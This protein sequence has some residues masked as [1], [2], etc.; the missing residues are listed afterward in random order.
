MEAESRKALWGE[1]LA[2]WIVTLLLIRLVVDAQR[3][4]GLHEVALVLVP[5]LFLY[6]PVLVCHWRKVDSWSYPLAIPRFRDKESWARIAKLNLWTIGVIVV[7][8]VVGYHLW[9]TQ[10]FPHILVEYFGRDPHRLQVAHLQWVWPSAFIGW[11]TLLA[12]AVQLVGYHLF[13]VAI[14]EEV[15][16]RG[17]LQTRFDEHFGTPWKVLGANVGWGL[18]LTCVLFAFGHSLIA[19]QWWHAFIFFPSLVFGWMRAKTGGPMAGALFHAWSN[20]TVA[21]LDRLYGVIPA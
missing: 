8:F 3:M 2:L 17:Y 1:L 9:H 20:V 11:W 18:V 16:Y 15:F 5:V 19:P 10:I 21:T 6:A 14:P 4:W 12:S 13:F 7:P